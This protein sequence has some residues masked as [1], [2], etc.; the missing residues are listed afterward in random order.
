MKKPI[1]IEPAEDGTPESTLGEHY[2]KEERTVRWCP[3]GSLPTEHGTYQSVHSGYVWRQGKKE[4]VIETR[5]GKWL[6]HELSNVIIVDDD[7]K[8]VR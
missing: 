1:E 5:T 3:P 2:D 6:L 8:A 4:F 7:N